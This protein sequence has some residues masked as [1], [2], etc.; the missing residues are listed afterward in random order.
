MTFAV[1]AAESLGVRAMAVLVQGLA[2]GDLLIDPGAALGPRRYGLA[3]HEV[4]EDAL[5]AAR[6]RILAA[7]VGRI[8]ITHFHHDHF[9]PFETHRWVIGGFDDACRL[10]AGRT[11]YRRDP[12]GPMNAR[13]R[14]R[15][16]HLTRQL[17]ALDVPQRSI[18]ARTWD[19]LV[20]SPPLLHGDEGSPGG[21]VVMVAVRSAHDTLVHM[22]DT[23]LLNAAAVDWALRQRPSIVVTSGPPL[24]LPQLG[25]D[26]LAPARQNLRRLVDAV[27][28]VVV[29]HHLMRGGE[30]EA[31][32]APARALA[33]PRDHRL[34]CG[35]EWMGQPPM[36][37][38]SRR[39]ELYGSET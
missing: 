24:Y 35:A 28:L 29:D 26:R 37:L 1:L 23:Q 33:E 8:V 10:Y 16:Q 27:P 32:L 20:F 12:S 11:V 17:A 13:Q 4:E 2:G 31:F 18:D 30:P 38:E 9:V 34:L 7:S 19:D 21:W 14:G 36:L 5:E 6:A 3:P 15:A 39:R 22:S 25:G